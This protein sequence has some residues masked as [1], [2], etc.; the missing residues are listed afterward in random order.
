MLVFIVVAVPA[1][2]REYS[3]LAALA[4]ITHCPSAHAINI[5]P[6]TPLISVPTQAAL[7]TVMSE[8]DVWFAELIVNLFVV[9]LKETISVLS[10]TALSHVCI[11]V[12]INVI[13]VSV[14]K[15]NHET[16]LNVPS[17]VILKLPAVTAFHVAITIVAVIPV[18][19]VGV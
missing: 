7:V 8:V 2:V 10:V 14:A 4:V 1:S 15:F 17:I 18:T 6:H 12:A 16:V 13:V 9:V 5:V 11:F 3:L 19:D